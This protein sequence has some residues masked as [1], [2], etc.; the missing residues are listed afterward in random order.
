MKKAAKPSST[1][2]QSNEQAEAL[3]H[4]EKLGSKFMSMFDDDDED[5]NTT[6]QQ[7]DEHSNSDSEERNNT[8]QQQPATAPN[9]NNK[10]QKAVKQQ[11]PKVPVATIPQKPSV[12]MTVFD[13]KRFDPRLSKA[14][15]TIDQSSSAK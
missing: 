12:K 6:Q 11:V 7:Q 5:D 9:A 1:P 10:Q 13:D 15:P 3:K 2:A 8:Q 14:Q 4:L